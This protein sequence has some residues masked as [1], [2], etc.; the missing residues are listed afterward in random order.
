MVKPMGRKKL[1]IQAAFWIMLATFGSR[2][3]G[4]LREV[5]LAYFF[6]LTPMRGAFTVAFKIPN[7]IRLLIADAAISAA[8]IPVFTE[9]LMKKDKD[10]AWRVG[11]QMMNVVFLIL[12]L[13]VLLCEIFM[14][15]IIQ[16]T[17]PGFTRDRELFQHTVQLSRII[18]PIIII[19][20]LGGVV[21]GIL[22]SMQYFGAAAVAPL[23]W[24]VINI[25]AVFL[26]YHIGGIYAAAWGLL[27]ATII[28]FMIQGSP[29]TQI[30]RQIQWK[31]SW[32]LG[33]SDPV[34]KQIGL[35]M[36]PVTLSIGVINFNAL[37]GNFFASLLGPAE[38][39][40]IDSAFR[41]FHLPQGMF[42]IAIG[43]VLFPL[44]SGF[45]VRDEHQRFSNVIQTGLRQIFFATLPFTG[46]FMTLSF[47]IAKVCFERGQFSES[48]SR[49]V[50]W[51]LL[52][53]AIGMSF[54]SANT[55]LNRGFYSL[56]KTWIPLYTS[57]INIGLNI[58][59][60][61]LLLKP[62]GVGG[63]CFATSFVSICNFFALSYLMKRE[64]KEFN[65]K[66]VVAAMVRC[67]SLTLLL[68][69]VSYIS[70]HELY[71]WL[72]KSFWAL[73]FSLGGGI[74]AGAIIYA[75]VAWR[76]NFKEVEEALIL[77]RKE[78]PSVS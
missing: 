10:E 17:T 36:I 15:F 23:F 57:V 16:I 8:F 42:A 1:L 34:M 30:P 43:T 32:R 5:Q 72:G 31:Y 55:L 49:L 11:S 73:L 41:L 52:F 66:P 37:V 27:A 4:F 28:Q 78:K 53:Y 70:Y 45:V 6:G 18:F 29:F 48:D 63:I 14:P 68:A 3:L 44:L 22:H 71:T 65:L 39:A 54:T 2:L 75:G 9:L 40:A 58:L 69:I 7:L 46:W 50:A 19:L 25:L 77:V 20:G 21:V 51:A 35:L 61:W 47:P 24:N 67:V 62:L 76:F 12:T 33:L 64:V 59:L 38:V 26:F 74:F 13:I 60:C 56:K